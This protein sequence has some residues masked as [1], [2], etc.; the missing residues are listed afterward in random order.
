[1][2][3]KIFE[4]P[5][6]SVVDP[7]LSDNDDDDYCHIAMSEIKAYCGAIDRRGITCTTSVPYDQVGPVCPGCGHLVCQTCLTLWGLECQLR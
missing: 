6:R 3:T 7:R 4:P 2:T 5:P 1:M